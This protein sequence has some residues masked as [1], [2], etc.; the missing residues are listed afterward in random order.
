MNE[1]IDGKTDNK[2][3]GLLGILWRLR[4]VLD[5]YCLICANWGAIE[6]GGGRNFFSFVNMSFLDL[7]VLYICKVFEEEKTDERG[8]V[9]YE[10]DSIAGVLRSIDDEKA[11]VLDP[12]RIR[13]F[14]QKYGGDSD[15][16][17]LP[18]IEAVVQEFRKEHDKA[19][20]GFKTL[21]NKWVAHS[22][23]EFSPKDAPSYD[24]MERLFNFGLD[25]Y[26][27]VSEAF[28]SVGPC[29]LNADRTVKASLKGVLKALG[30]EEI[31]NEME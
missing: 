16:E 14:V 11:A 22:E 21:R 1:M 13:D 29:N 18:A 7:V 26:M 3:I 19:I 25:F 15:K 8:A 4:Q 23:S 17:G 6:K 24:V 2:N 30:I 12:A 31:R 5:V 10:L 27:L 28:I 9:R 20:S